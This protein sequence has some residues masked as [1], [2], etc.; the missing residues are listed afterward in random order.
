[1]QRR[2]TRAECKVAM[3]TVARDLF[4]D[5]A[6][7]GIAGVFV[8]WFAT[9]DF[10]AWGA[11]EHAAH[12]FNVMRECSFVWLVLVFLSF[13]PS[14]RAIRTAGTNIVLAPSLRACEFSSWVMGAYLCLFALPCTALIINTIQ[15]D[16]LA[17]K[18]LTSEL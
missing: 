16:R 18:I 12:A 1:M 14:L 15:N 4:R 9:A 3:L 17:E 11:T 7:F 2:L 8:L 13:A 10:A 6:I 5:A